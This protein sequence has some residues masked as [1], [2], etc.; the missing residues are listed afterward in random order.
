VHLC[1]L[2]EKFIR[3]VKVLLM[4]LDGLQSV[5]KRTR[6]DRLNSALTLT[7]A[8][9]G[10]YLKYGADRPMIFKREDWDKEEA[11]SPSARKSKKDI[12]RFTRSVLRIKGG[13]A[14]EKKFN[15]VIDTISSIT[16]GSTKEE[17]TSSEEWKAEIQGRSL[18]SAGYTNPGWKALHWTMS[19]RTNG[20]ILR[21]RT[22]KNER[23]EAAT[24]WSA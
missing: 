13:D 19:K 17:L 22:A 18:T 8:L 7:Q 16:I 11:Y 10:N 23:G 15:K 20:G 12:D 24:S 4:P 2:P 6:A 9:Q 5:T 14:A 21:H 1:L 3:L